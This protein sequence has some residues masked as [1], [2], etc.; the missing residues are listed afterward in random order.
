MCNTDINLFMRNGL[1]YLNSLDRS[2]LNIRGVWLVFIIPCFIEIH[3]FNANSVDPDQTPQNAASD[4]GLH[5]LLMSLLW[6]ARLKS[7]KDSSQPTYPGSLLLTYSQV[8]ESL[9][10]LCMHCLQLCLCSPNFKVE[11]AYCTWVVHASVR[12]VRKIAW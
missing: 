4:L 2:I 1:F 8:L 5:C 11:G 12:L 6:D 10:R 7:G 9:I 3:V